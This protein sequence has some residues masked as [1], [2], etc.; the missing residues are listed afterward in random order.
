MVAPDSHA[1][2]ERLLPMGR[3]AAFTIVLDGDRAGD[4]A[5]RWLA[6]LALLA[7]PRQRLSLAYAKPTLVVAVIS[8]TT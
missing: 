5:W 3:V 8:F 2:R 1:E 7:R 6:G 4:P